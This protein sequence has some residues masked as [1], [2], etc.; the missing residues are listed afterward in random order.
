M[1]THYSLARFAQWLVAAT[2]A[3]VG[4]F[5]MLRI[6]RK[7]RQRQD[8]VHRL[9]QEI[10]QVAQSIEVDLHTLPRTS[11]AAELA[12]RGA[13]CRT[14]A[15]EVAASRCRTEQA[16]HDAIG[17]LHEDH[18]RVVDLRWELDAVMAERRTGQPAPRSCKF[19]TGSK[20]TRSRWATTGLHTRPSTLG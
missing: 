5:W 15:R 2:A 6:Q 11:E 19:A 18:R 7:R 9:A 17:Q 10:V 20:P 14:R 8:H 4:A 12:R 3:A 13:D 1:I 16:L